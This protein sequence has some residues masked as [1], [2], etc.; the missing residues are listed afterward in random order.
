MFTCSLFYLSRQFF[1]DLK[2][3]ILVVRRSCAVLQKRSNLSWW[4]STFRFAS[5]QTEGKLNVSSLS[6][7]TGIR[8]TLY[9]KETAKFNY[10]LFY[11]SFFIC[12]NLRKLDLSKKSR[13]VLWKMLKSV[14]EFPVT[15]LGRKILE[16]FPMKFVFLISF[17][18]RILF[19]DLFLICKMREI[20]YLQIW[21]L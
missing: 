11:A 19:F 7:V 2:L 9:Y 10:V 8:H 16:M 13:K 6:S 3:P 5:P 17:P 18:K 21:N 12:S 15:F 4:T 20:Y 1:F 14:V